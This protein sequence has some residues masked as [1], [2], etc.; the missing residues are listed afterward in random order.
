MNE[1]TSDKSFFDTKDAAEYCGLT[2]RG[3][4]SAIYESHRLK[5]DGTI[6]GS[7][8]F[9]RATLDAFNASRRPPGRPSKETARKGA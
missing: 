4:K 9:H 2:V 7:L 5:E 3:L 1:S 6:G 8:F